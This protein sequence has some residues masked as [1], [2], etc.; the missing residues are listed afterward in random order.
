M[1]RVTLFLPA[2]WVQET[3]SA[4]T[5]LSSL[6]LLFLQS[7]IWVYGAVSAVNQQKPLPNVTLVWHDAWQLRDWPLSFSFFF[8]HWS[9]TMKLGYTIL[10]RFADLLQAPSR[11]SQTVY[12]PEVFWQRNKSWI[13]CPYLF[14]SAGTAPTACLPS[15][16]LFAATNNCYFWS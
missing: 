14:W 1:K 12:I 11:P 5:F 3:H 10:W 15:C 8:H 6:H 13:A 16:S 4:N 7:L 9:K 2:F